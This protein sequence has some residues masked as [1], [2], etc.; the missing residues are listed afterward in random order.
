MLSHRTWMATRRSVV[1]RAASGS[2]GGVASALRC[3]I[4]C[5]FAP[6]AFCSV[7]HLV[8]VCDACVDDCRPFKGLSPLAQQCAVYRPPS[9]RP[10]FGNRCQTFEGH[11]RRDDIYDG[12]SFR[13]ENDTRFRTYCIIM[14]QQIVIVILLLLLLLV[15]VLTVC[16]RFACAYA[17][18][19]TSAFFVF[20]L[21]IPDLGL[22]YRQCTRHTG[23]RVCRR[24]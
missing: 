18:R 2:T 15:V 5:R 8:R 4:C 24:G 1:Y 14:L 10:F 9:A 21:I 17:I 11:I 20:F 16:Y 7:R 19:R 23:R 6:G 3:H 12:R 22:T 13:F